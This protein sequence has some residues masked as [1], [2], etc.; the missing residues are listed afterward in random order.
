MHPQYLLLLLLLLS[1][2]TDKTEDLAVVGEDKS[3]YSD[4][5]CMSPPV[6]SR[7]LNRSKAPDARYLSF[8][9]I[10]DRKIRFLTCIPCQTF[11]LTICC[12]SA[13]ITG[14]AS[15]PL[16]LI[17]IFTEI[18]N[19]NSVSLQCFRIASWQRIVEE[20]WKKVKALYCGQ[21]KLSSDE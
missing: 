1:L 9:N 8:R 17:A 13:M 16:S 20:K 2:K 21:G 7:A 12:S 6:T 4:L 3:S 18:V 15:S 5:F 11:L 10:D 19:A 14:R